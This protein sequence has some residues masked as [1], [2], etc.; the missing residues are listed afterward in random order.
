MTQE[1]NF[2]YFINNF[3]LG[4]TGCSISKRQGKSCF[5][6]FRHQLN[7]LSDNELQLETIL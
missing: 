6:L 3:T 4:N 2:L 7:T 5:Y 1:N